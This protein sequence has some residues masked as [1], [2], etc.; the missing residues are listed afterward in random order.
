[1]AVIN[2]NECKLAGAVFVCLVLVDETYCLTAATDFSSSGAS[3]V[4]FEL[5]YFLALLDM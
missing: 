2:H 5:V 4:E 1:M 3:G